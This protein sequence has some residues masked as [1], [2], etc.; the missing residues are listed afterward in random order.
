L[1]WLESPDSVDIAQEIN[2]LLGLLVTN[3]RCYEE[4]TD[5][6]T[7]VNTRDIDGG[8]VE[9]LMEEVREL[10]KRIRASQ[11]RRKQFIAER[12]K[13]SVGED[14]SWDEVCEYLMKR[15]KDE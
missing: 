11:I 1:R 15:R 10:R 14:A 8:A 12:L 5:Q 2:F 3:E 7:P 13:G 4:S 9:D 6:V